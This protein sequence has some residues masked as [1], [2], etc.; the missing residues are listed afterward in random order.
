MLSQGN[1]LLP[2]QKNRSRAKLLIAKQEEIDCM[3]VVVSY[4]SL[5]L[6]Q[7][8][9]IDLSILL[10]GVCAEVITAPL[11]F[12]FSLCYKIDWP[13]TLHFHCLTQQI[14][15]NLLRKVVL[16]NI[17]LS[18]LFRY[19]SVAFKDQRNFSGLCLFQIPKLAFSRAFA[20]LSIRVLTSSFWLSCPA[21]LTQQQAQG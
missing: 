19:I 15:L 13:K 12:V 11:L 5:L 20:F 10:W 14:R 6:V 18:C 9:N 8:N 3:A 21:T 17:S 16:R 7:M 2:V 4:S 1:G